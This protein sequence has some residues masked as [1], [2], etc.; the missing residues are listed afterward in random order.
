M[1]RNIIKDLINI[2]NYL[3]STIINFF[4]VKSLNIFSVKMLIAFRTVNIYLMLKEIFK[5]R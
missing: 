1:L 4:V 5:R 3:T 2:K